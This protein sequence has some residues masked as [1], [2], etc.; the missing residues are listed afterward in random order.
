MT[1]MPKSLCLDE[2]YM[3]M[4]MARLGRPAREARLEQPDR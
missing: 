4:R 1:L 3:K 2:A